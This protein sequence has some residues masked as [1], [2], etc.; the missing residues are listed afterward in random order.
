VPSGFTGAGLP[1]SLQVLCHAGQEATALR[2]A[3]AYE[4]ANNW[5][6]RR[7]PIA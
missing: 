3:W 7:P 4:Q 1:T 6:E 2:I 5:R